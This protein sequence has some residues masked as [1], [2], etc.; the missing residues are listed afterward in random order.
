MAKLSNIR[1]ET[2]ELYYIVESHIKQ[3]AFK[4]VQS[5]LASLTRLE[6]EL[7]AAS[8]LVIIHD[9]A[10]MSTTEATS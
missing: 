9:V 10:N 7:L 4:T 6:L 3:G 5:Y 1:R 2:D 8:C